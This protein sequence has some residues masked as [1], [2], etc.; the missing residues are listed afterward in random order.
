[1]NSARWWRIVRMPFFV[2][3]FGYL[4]LAVAAPFLAEAMLYYPK[5]GSFR[6]PGGMRKIRGSDGRS[7]AVLHLPNPQAWFTLW[8]FHG[9]AEDLGDI[10]PQ[11]RMFQAAGF[12]VFAC[13]Y[14]GYGHTEGR[15]SEAALNAAART[16]RTYLREELRV[17][18]ERTLL[19][20]R[21]LGNG[22]AVQLATE[23]RLGGLIVQS[24]FLSVFRVMTRWPLLPFDQF[25][26]LKKMPFVRCPVLVIH[27]RADEVISF[28]HG[29]ALLEAAPGPKQHLWLS[30]AGHNNLVDVAGDR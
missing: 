10:E 28:H 13:E 22:P 25:K 17:P 7:I 23:E 6:A 26:N 11:L 20:G 9:N 4:A 2:L 15:P 18:A 14:P 29:E 27:G 8:F 16:A 21:S 5:F 12:A 30:G 19:H 3:L 24:G 1:M